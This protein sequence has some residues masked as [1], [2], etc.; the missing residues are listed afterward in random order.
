MS[1]PT[2]S[3][4]DNFDRANNPTSLGPP[5]TATVYGSEPSVMGINNNQAVPS[6]DGIASSA[7]YD[8]SDYGPDCEAYV[9]F[10]TITVSGVAYLYARLNWAG[11]VDGYRIRF[12]TTTCRF[13][14]IDNGV[15][16]TLGSDTSVTF[17]DG[18]SGGLEMVSD[19]LNAHQKTGGS[20]SLIDSRT[21]ATYAGAGK[22]GIGTDNGSTFPVKLDNFGSGTISTG[23]PPY[24]KTGAGIIG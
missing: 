16:T 10:S 13:Q 3:V 9:D 6:G 12:T 19:S 18:D 2:T 21:D 5:W 8:P 1:F 7:Y 4:I 24:V 14:R 15:N 22:T 23:P 17:A 20:W 11:T